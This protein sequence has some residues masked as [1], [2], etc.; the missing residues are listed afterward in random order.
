M[1]TSWF[2]LKINFQNKILENHELMEKSPDINIDIRK[3]L[4]VLDK[5]F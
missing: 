5:R 2:Q 4:K 3:K 1:K